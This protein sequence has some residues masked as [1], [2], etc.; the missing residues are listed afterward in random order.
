MSEEPEYYCLTPELRT[1]LEFL[2]EEETHLVD[3][4]LRTRKQSGIRV[5]RTYKSAIVLFIL[6]IHKHIFELTENDV[7]D[8]YYYLEDTRKLKYST[9]I[10]TQAMLVSFFNQSEK[11]LKKMNP[12]FE[13]PIPK[14]FK[15]KMNAIMS[16]ADQE[17]ALKDAVFTIDEL[18]QLI[19]LSWYRTY[20]VYLNSPKEQFII[21][22]LCIFTGARISEI[23]SIKKA[24]VN[25][26]ERW[27][28]T[29][30]EEGARKSTHK[31]N[32]PLIFCFPPVIAI[33]IHEYLLQLNEIDQSDWLFPGLNPKKHITEA[34]IW[35]YLKGMN[36]ANMPET[37]KRAH[38]FRHTLTTFMRNKFNR[39]DKD[40][41]ERLTN[42]VLSGVT[43]QVY[44]TWSISE[45]REIYDASLPREYSIL[46]ELI[47][48]L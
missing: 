10:H 22:L 11:R 37:K 2:T 9:K 34:A 44:V 39:V 28:R 38:I 4:F 20:K 33:Q 43:E 36:I 29:G 17:Q 42:H 30:I 27:L 15:F 16:K 12:G 41:V 21:I 35:Y 7:E 47:Q 13:N 40:D 26:D 32:E 24:D 6:Y 31:T 8:Y 48:K 3:R 45:R 5:M 23:V 46:I 25:T 1:Q 19:L 18:K 14:S